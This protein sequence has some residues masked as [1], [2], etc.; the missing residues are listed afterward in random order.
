[1]EIVLVRWVDPSPV[2]SRTA[3][4]IFQFVTLQQGGKRTSH[5]RLS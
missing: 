3:A 4:R 5:T 2:L 1:M